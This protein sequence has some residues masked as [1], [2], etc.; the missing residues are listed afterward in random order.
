MPKPATD[1]LKEAR[2]IANDAG[3]FFT[4]KGEEFTL[5][6]KTPAR[7]VYLGKRS[8]AANLCSFVK[9]CAASK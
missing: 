1:Y 3:L 4:C 8:S 5:Y 6:R 9:R 2:R 7:V